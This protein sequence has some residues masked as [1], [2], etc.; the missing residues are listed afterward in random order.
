MAWLTTVPT[1]QLQSVTTNPS[2]EDRS[3][4]YRHSAELILNWG[5]RLTT[6]ETTRTSEADGVAQAAAEA[7]QAASP[8]RSITYGSV[9]VSTSGIGLAL[10]IISREVVTIRSIARSN[11]AGAYRLTETVTVTT[12]SGVNLNVR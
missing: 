1:L 12:T 4:Q 11:N 10:R 3:G 7:W 6:T 5:A 2:F 9:D 8:S